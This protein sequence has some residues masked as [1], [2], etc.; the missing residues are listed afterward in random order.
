MKRFKNIGGPH[1]EPSV[2]GI[3]PEKVPFVKGDVVTTPRDLCAL[4]PGKFELIVEVEP[5]VVTPARRA[6]VQELIDGGVWL[7]EDRS[8]LEQLTDTNFTRV[9]RQTAPAKS[10]D[11]SKSTV[12]GDDV[13][14]EF[15]Q[16]YDEGYKVYVNAQGKYQVVK[17]RSKKPLN[18][19]PLEKTQVEEFVSEHLKG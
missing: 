19:E 18:E 7:E 8:F 14:D 2:E 4:Y 13:T 5:V 3:A 15:Q 12:L 9:T 10:V 1:Y 6:A 16:A 11:H 17:G